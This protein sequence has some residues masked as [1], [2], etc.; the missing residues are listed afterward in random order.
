MAAPLQRTYMGRLHVGLC[1][2]HLKNLKGK[3]HLDSEGNPVVDA[4]GKVL[5]DMPSAAMLK[6]IREFLKDNGIDSEAIEGEPV[7]QVAKQLRQ[8]DDEP[9][10]FLVESD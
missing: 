8:F 7:T 9:D 1:Q 5:M 6:E 2:V 10:P 4:Q 3:P